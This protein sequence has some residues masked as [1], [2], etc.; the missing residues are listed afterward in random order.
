MKPPQ[1]IQTAVTTRRIS[2]LGYGRTRERNAVNRF[3]QCE[4]VT[5]LSVGHSAWGLRL[6]TAHH[7]GVNIFDKCAEY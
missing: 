4:F 1:P 6:N 3:T 7:Y 5:S 2:G